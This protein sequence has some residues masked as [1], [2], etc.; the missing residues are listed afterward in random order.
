M[1]IDTRQKDEDR[2]GIL[3]IVEH[4]EFAIFHL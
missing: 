2:Q 1:L 3:I 4:R